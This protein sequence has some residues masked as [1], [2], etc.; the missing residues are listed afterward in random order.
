M[1][2]KAQK[3]KGQVYLGAHVAIIKPETRHGVVNKATKGLEYQ[4]DVSLVKIQLG[5]LMGHPTGDTV[6]EAGN[7]TLGLES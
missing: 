4:D 7:E 6:Q 5:E 3:R 1:R 2:T